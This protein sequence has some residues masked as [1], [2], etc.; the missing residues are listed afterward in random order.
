MS[1][2]KLGKILIALGAFAGVVALWMKRSTTTS[3]PVLYPE[4]IA[5]QNDYMATNT[6]TP[7]GYR[8]NNPLNIR[9]SSSNWLG[10]IPVDKNTDGVFEQF[11]TM[12]HGYRA[13][14][15]LLRNYVNKYKCDTLA[16]II[17][18]WA[19]ANENNTAGYIK[20]VSKSMG[21]PADTFINPYSQALMSSLVRAMSLVENGTKIQPDDNAIR[22]AWEL[23]A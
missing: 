15:V 12:A 23:Y 20:R 9:I 1:N 18:R 17:T 10:K 14:M 13:A 22:E 7:R 2:D 11:E 3:V 4:Q 19:P 5:N 21:V 16:K 8:N 6:K